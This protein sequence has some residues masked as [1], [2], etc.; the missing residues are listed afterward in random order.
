MSA[1]LLTDEDIQDTLPYIEESLS[2][3]SADDRLLCLDD[4]KRYGTFQIDNNN[5]VA[6]KNWKFY[7]GESDAPNPP[8][9]AKE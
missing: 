6:P 5:R 2:Q 7:Q 9:Q 3:L 8:E 4:L 1:Y